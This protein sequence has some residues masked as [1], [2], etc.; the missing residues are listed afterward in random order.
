M[1][2]RASA[3]ADAVRVCARV[4]G[5]ACVRVRACAPACVARLCADSDALTLCPAV[6]PYIQFGGSDKNATALL[7]GLV[8]RQAM[9]VSLDPFANAFQLEGSSPSPHDD[10]STTYVGYGLG[11]ALIARGLCWCRRSLLV[12]S[13][14]TRP[15]AS[16]R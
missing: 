9:F 11:H 3:V 1:R 2:I 7:R 5:C 16:T 14:A 15:A 12:C 13:T 4:S 8:R 6:A 10:D